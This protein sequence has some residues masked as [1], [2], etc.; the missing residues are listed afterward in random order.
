MICFIEI[1][2]LE[3]LLLARKSRLWGGG[4]G[5]GLAQLTIFISKR[6]LIQKPG[7]K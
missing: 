5:E 7:I 4:V 6:Y 1:P 2:S 3:N